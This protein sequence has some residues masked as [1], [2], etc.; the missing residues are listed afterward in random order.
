MPVIVVLSAEEVTFG[1]HLA[2]SCWWRPVCGLTGLLNASQEGELAMKR[3]L[4]TLATTAA[5]LVGGLVATQTAEAR[6]VRYGGWGYTYAYRPYYYGPRPFVYAAPRYYYN[7]YP[8]AY[9]YGGPYYGGPAVYVG[10][11]AGY[12]YRY[13]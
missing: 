12:Y 10:P 8:R 5:L 7:G 9:Y 11:R 13:W 1:L 6:P 4:L 3:M 2:T